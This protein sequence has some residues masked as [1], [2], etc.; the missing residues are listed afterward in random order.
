MTFLAA[1]KPQATLLPWLQC[2]YV[3]NSVVARDW[4]LTA[5]NRLEVSRR[6]AV[7]DK[8]LVIPTYVQSSYII[9]HSNFARCI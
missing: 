8:G 6:R 2:T 5:C 9:I 4:P 1:V 7:S 3:N